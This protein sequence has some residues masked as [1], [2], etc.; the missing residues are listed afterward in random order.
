MENQVANQIEKTV[1]QLKK[2]GF[3]GAKIELEANLDRGTSRNCDYCDEGQVSCDCE[4]DEVECWDCDGEGVVTSS[5]NVT[6]DCEQCEGRGRTYCQDCEDGYRTCNE[7]DGDYRQGSDE[8]DETACLEYILARLEAKLGRSHDNCIETGYDDHDYAYIEDPFPE[9]AYMRF[10]ND[11]SVDSELTASSPLDHVDV[12]P[13]LVEAFRELGEAIGNGIEV[14]G[15][16]MHFSLLSES[17]CSYDPDE[18]MRVPNVSECYHNF[19]KSM[20]LLLP[21]LFF[22]GTPNSQSRGLGYRKPRISSD[23]YS[24]VHIGGNALEFRVFDTCYDQPEA[25]LDDFVV[26]GNCMKYWSPRYVPSGLNKVVKEIRFGNDNGQNLSRLYATG[27][28]IDMLNAGIAKLKP[29]Y[30]TI[31]ELKQQRGFK[32]TKRDTNKVLDERKKEA[33][34]QYEE[35]ENRFAWSLKT[36]EILEK[37]YAL[38]RTTPRSPEEEE[39]VIA[40]A[41]ERAKELV[42]RKR[43]TKQTLEY[44][45]N[46]A[47][48]NFLVSV[49]GEYSL[50]E[51]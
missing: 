39:R 33:T 35:Y 41:E 44:Y 22:L 24:A 28:H 6:T 1:K 32:V 9:I 7:C 13:K 45:T 29:S 40:M 46:E 19:K 20:Q 36:T 50:G 23:K 48:N 21:A 4:G 25:V 30:Y 5:A 38:E 26:I 47:V 43:L 27:D 42:E 34:V 10:Y 3:H 37:G 16:G 18:G 2:K 14:D 8:W 51:Y 49:S 12:S 31:R 17:D 11:G 15:A